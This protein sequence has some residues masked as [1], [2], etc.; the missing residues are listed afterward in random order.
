MIRVRRSQS[1]VRLDMTPLIDVVFLL[2]TFF[3]FSLVLLVRADVLDVRL[4]SIEAGSQPGGEVITLA[5]DR[6]GNLFLEGDPTTLND[7]AA[8]VRA[9]RS[10]RPQAGLVLAVDREG[11]SEDLIRLVELLS[12]E[13]LGDF[14]L[15]GMQPTAPSTE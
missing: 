8:K 2:L 7:V 12:R 10:E 4:P 3:I 11:R 6:T 14:G 13:G 15:L 9:L 1:E 5:L